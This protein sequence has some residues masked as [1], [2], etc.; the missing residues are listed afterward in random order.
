VNVLRQALGQFEN[1]QVMGRNGIKYNNQD[2]SMMTALMV[3]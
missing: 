2:H 3:A 1:F